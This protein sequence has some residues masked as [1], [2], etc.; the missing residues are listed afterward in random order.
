[1]IDIQEHLS[2]IIIALLIVIIIYLAYKYYFSKQKIFLL[3]N[4]IAE[5]NKIKYL[6]NTIDTK[7]NSKTK[8]NQ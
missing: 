4:K 7:T 2:K 3:E 8:I 6:E 5:L 1:M